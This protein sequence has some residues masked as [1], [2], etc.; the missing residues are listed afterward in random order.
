[1]SFLTQHLVLSL[2]PEAGDLHKFYSQ[3]WTI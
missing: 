2:G 3:F 1:M